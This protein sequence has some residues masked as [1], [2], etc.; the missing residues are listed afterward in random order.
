MKRIRLCAT[1]WKESWTGRKL[2]TIVSGA[3]V[4]WFSSRAEPVPPG[5]SKKLFE[6]LPLSL[7]YPQYPQTLT[8]IGALTA[9]TLN[10]SDDWGGMPI[11]ETVSQSSS[12]CPKNFPNACVPGPGGFTVGNPDTAFACVSYSGGQC[13]NQIN[14]GDQFPPTTNVSYDK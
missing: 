5:A 7:T 8:G 11:T 12:T 14:I 13:T 9:V 2:R 6:S 3:Q 10:D 1:G 4:Y